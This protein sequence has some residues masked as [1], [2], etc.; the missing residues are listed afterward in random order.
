[1][2]VVMGVSRK[3]FSLPPEPGAEIPSRACKRTIGKLHC[4]SERVL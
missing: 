3:K 4:T 2:L 1:L